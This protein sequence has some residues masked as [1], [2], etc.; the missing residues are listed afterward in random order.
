VGMGVRCLKKGRY[1]MFNK[2]AKERLR[3]QYEAKRLAATEATML[4]LT[5]NEVGD[6]S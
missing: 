5:L 4:F 3:W 2:E 1:D 6:L